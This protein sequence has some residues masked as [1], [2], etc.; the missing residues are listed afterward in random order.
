MSNN[1]P[2]ACR[3]A[4]TEHSD[5]LR[6]PP[7]PPTRPMECHNPIDL[8]PYVKDLKTVFM[9]PCMPCIPCH[10][11]HVKLAIDSLPTRHVGC[12]KPATRWERWESQQALPRRRILGTP[13]WMK[14]IHYHAGPSPPSDSNNHSERKRHRRLRQILPIHRNPSMLGS[15]RSKFVVHLRHDLIDA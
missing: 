12:H 15:G 9:R 7:P 6:S 8:E 14:L 3:V 5:A 2:A 11:N 13:G 10:A 1:P 4:V